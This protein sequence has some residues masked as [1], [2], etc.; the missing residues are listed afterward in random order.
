MNNVKKDEMFPFAITM[1]GMVEDLENLKLPNI[2]MLQQWREYQE[3]TLVF[4]LVLF[5]AKCL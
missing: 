5:L 2:E 1:D 4:L 3:R